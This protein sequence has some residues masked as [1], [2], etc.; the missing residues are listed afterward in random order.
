MSEV[1]IPGYILPHLLCQTA[2]TVSSNDI[3]KYTRV[4]LKRSASLCA[5][6]PLHPG[7]LHSSQRLRN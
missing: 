1:Y 6:Q 5:S 2:L 4:E 7:G 3:E